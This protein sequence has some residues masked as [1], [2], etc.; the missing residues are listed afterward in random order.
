[1]NLQRIFAFLAA[2]C[3]LLAA[4]GDKDGITDAD[5]EDGELLDCCQVGTSRASLLAGH[6]ASA[7]SG[8]SPTSGEAAK[9]E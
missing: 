7:T 8:V 4:C 5:I 3:L 6:A 9:P 2:A 1:M